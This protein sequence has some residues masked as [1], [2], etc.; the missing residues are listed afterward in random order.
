MAKEP[1][2][3]APKAAEEEKKALAT[4][5]QTLPAEAVSD[6]YEDAGIDSFRAEDVALPYVTILQTTS[7]QVKKQKANFIEGAEVGMFVNTATERLF[8]GEDG[9]D[10][11]VA[12]SVKEWVEWKPEMGGFVRNWGQDESR[13]NQSQQDDTGRWKT[14]D[15]N[16][17]VETGVLYVLMLDLKNPDALPER[18]IISL[19]GTQFKKFKKLNAMITSFVLPRPD[20]KGSFTPACFARAYHAVSVPEENDKGDWFGWK[21]TALDRT[22]N[23]PGGADLY[24][25]AKAFRELIDKGEVRVAPPPGAEPAAGAPTGKKDDK[26]DDIPF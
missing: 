9:I 24:Q 21:I 11:I 3:S 14:P 22:H 10:F 15:G 4:V 12:K 8:K 16:D 7:E 19:S 26:D 1:K 2:A 25:Q 18:A 20:G 13:R 23:L 17:L 5:K 6:L